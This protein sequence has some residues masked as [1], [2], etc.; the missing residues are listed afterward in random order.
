M[1]TLSVSAALAVALLVTTTIQPVPAL[2]QERTI[3]EI[4]VTAR[5]REETLQDVPVTVAVFTEEDLQRYGITTL[6]EASKLVPNFRIFHGGSG[7]GSNL[8]LRGVGS[9]SISAAFDQSVAVN[10]D[11]V[12]VNIGRFI[13]NSYMDMAQLEVLKGPQSLYFGKSATAGVVSVT[14]KDPTDEFEFEVM[15]G[16]ENEY[17]QTYTELI[18]SGPLTDTLSARLAA[19][20][21]ESEELYENLW[22][23]VAHHWRGEDAT[24]IRLTLLWEPADF[25]RARLKYSYSD[26]NN[27]GANGVTEEICPEGSVQ[28]TAIPAASFA[29]GTFAGIDDC[30][31]NGN[32]SINDLLP[33]LR[34]GLPHGGDDGVP[35]LE[36]ETDFAVFQIDYDISDTL[37]LT[38]VTGYV[39]LEHW[40][41]DIYDYN[42][43]AFG[44]EHNNKYT[45]LSQ[46]FR[47]NSDFDSA[48]NF[49]AGFY[50]Q[51]IDQ[52]FNA[53]QFAFNLGLIFGPD[54]VTGNEY[55]YNKNHSLNTKV[56]STYI[57]GFW[58][59]TDTIELTAGVRY[60]DE[61]KDGRITLP[62]IHAGALAFG[63]GCTNP[64]DGCTIPLAPV[65]P[66]LEFEDDNTSPEI[67]IT[68]YV[69]PD[70]SVF[71]S[72]KEGFKSGGIDNSALP[73]ATLAQPT[74]ELS[75]F[76]Q[77][78]SETAE[79]YEIGT[80]A[81]LL[82]GSMR[83]N[84]TAFYYIYDDLQVQLFNA[85]IIQFETFN[86]SELTTQGVEF[87]VSW[88]PDIEGLTIRSAWA[89]TDA[90]YTDEF[91]NATGQDLDGET[92]VLSSDFAGNI[93]F[94][95]DRGL[96]GIWRWSLSVDARYDSGYN[97]SST[98]DPYE[99]DSFWLTDANLTL[100]SEDGRYELS[101]IGKNLGDETVAFL[102][103]ARPG[104][105]GQFNGANPP[106]SVC[107]F[108]TAN[109]Q[110]QVTGTSL[111]QQ[112][113]LRAR[114]R[115]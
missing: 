85:N 53:Y 104:S 111:G 64:A 110:D 89:W 47:L 112:F 48:L 17:D 36:Q 13:H 75:E 37:A 65:I 38:S 22:P 54:P 42:A 3:E 32:T 82:D 113:L 69:V 98:L 52:E 83:L 86:A 43:G 28:P 109:N 12:V 68:W 5:Q 84:A 71:A 60:T 2:A 101:L 72:Y 19:G 95:Y 6:T 30:K 93:G 1:R 44:G 16:Y 58:D 10:V 33:G 35:Y 79:G 108:T 41:L 55:D 115:L 87:D 67:A 34:T 114:F 77:Y 91:I 59:I 94:T 76:L 18:I 51:D 92:P 24:N 57:A 105:C 73:T 61:Q 4:I 39:D 9:S 31:L 11:G 46:E 66:G 25:F 29:L 50:Y 90:E 106:P 81:D 103:G 45:S 26:Y 80:K 107:T 70:I 40:E 62:Y 99:Q 14:T 8:Y 15:G 100:Y 23:D 96:T 20:Y 56:W 74:A 78:Q 97:I 63:F 21:T 7:N 102:A 27:D 88:L 49:A